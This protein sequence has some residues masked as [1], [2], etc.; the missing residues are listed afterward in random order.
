MNCEFRFPQDGAPEGVLVGA[1]GWAEEE[2][3]GRQVRWW[4]GFT[5]K[6]LTEDQQQ[7]ISV[8][9]NGKM[10][11]RPFK[12][13]R[14]QGTEGQL[15][16]EYLVGEVQA[17]WLDEGTDIDDDLIQSNRDQL[18]LEDGRLVPFIEWGRR[19]LAWALRERGNLRRAKALAG[20]EASP[21]V[22]ELLKPFTPRERTRY[23]GVAKALSKVNEIDDKG[24]VETMKTVI[25]AQSDRV[26]R[27]LMERIEEEDDPF[28]EKMW[29]LVS[30]VGLVDARRTQSLIA[31]RLSTIRSLK[32][33][34][35]NGAR[36]VPDIHKIVLKDP[37]L[38]DP[39]WS[40]LDDE[41][42][43]TKMGIAH[44]P[45][46]DEQGARLDFLFALAPKS[47]APLDEVVVVEIKRGTGNEGKPRKAT[48]LEVNKFHSYVLAVT[49]HYAKSSEQPAVRG[50][51]IAQ[52][53]T[54]G[55]D[56]LR[57]SLETIQNVRL[58]F[59][60]WDRVVDDTERMHMGWLAVSRDRLDA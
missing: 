9:A 49:N 53:Y 48:D 41:M 36:E 47:P 14:A 28:Q 15:G 3:D 56:Q 27:E 51:M 33:A 54:V 17:D 8:L 12:F 32:R 59:R 37:W 52:D 57:K 55:A 39:R 50:L 40:L 10:A 19:R 58:A 1:D 6:P 30:D 13:E 38:L 18:Q 34:V 45:E 26:V 7:G 11:Q 46:E 44:Q 43:L 5:E 20:F 25:D 35:H 31:A 24:I 4:F 60:T 16:Q 23:L 21:E 22:D 42:D 29:A 2:V